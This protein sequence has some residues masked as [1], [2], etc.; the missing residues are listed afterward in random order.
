MR[1]KFSSVFLLKYD[2]DHQ[3]KIEGTLADSECYGFGSGKG[4]LGGVRY[5]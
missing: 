5:A 3:R 2:D 4:L 1:K